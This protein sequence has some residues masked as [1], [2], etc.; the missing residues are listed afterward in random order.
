MLKILL[1]TLAAIFNFKIPIPADTKSK[2]N[3]KF[4]NC[5]I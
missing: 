2:F 5:K 4:F 3:R 1:R